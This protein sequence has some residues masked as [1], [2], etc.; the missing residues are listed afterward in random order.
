MH[1]RLREPRY[2]PVTAL[3]TSRRRPRRS[4]RVRTGEGIELRWEN[5]LAG[6]RSRPTGCGPGL[7]SCS[8]RH[9]A[10]WTVRR[11]R[12]IYLTG[13]GDSHYAGL[14]DAARLRALER[15]PDPGGRVA[16]TV[17]LRARARARRLLGVC[18][19]NSGK[20]VRTVEA[21]AEARQRG[22]RAIGVT[23][24]A[25]SP[26]AARRR[27][28][29]R[30]PLRRPGVRAGDDL[31]RRLPRRAVCAG[32]PRGRAGRR[33]AVEPDCQAGRGRP[34]DVRGVQCGLPS[35]SA[36]ETAGR[37]EGRL[38]RRRP[39]PRDGVVR[40]RED[41]RGR[42]R[43]GRS[44]RARG[45]GAR[46]VLLHRPRGDDDRRRAC[47][48]LRTTARSSSSP[49]HGRSAR[50]PSRSARPD[51]ARLP[52]QTS[53]F[54]SPATR[55]RLLSPLAYCVPLE[56]LAYHYASTRGLTMLGFDDEKRKALNFRQIFGEY[57]AR[58]L[59]VGN[60]LVENI[61]MPDGREL[62]DRLGGD[63]IYAASRRTGLR[64]RR[65]ARR[66]PWPGLSA[67]ACRRAR[68]GRV[69]GRPDPVRA[70]RRFGFASTGA[71]RTAAGSPSSPAPAHTS[72][73][74]RC[75]RSFPITSPTGSR[76]CTSRRSRSSRWRRGSTGRARARE[77]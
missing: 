29:A 11:R 49:P 31:L 14:A 10:C 71:S 65:P 59:T 16:R 7:P 27:G 77:C 23:F 1:P 54:P 55:P 22:L 69:R 26:L 52:R 40:A 24:D 19:S 67:R 50:R 12:A 68:A 44:A 74:R 21:A 43:A 72:R 37:R 28:D 47:P 51:R 8:R 2:E 75:P 36:R 64:R 30:L 53:C 76:R 48:A 17:A 18:V 32:S 25:D 34:P 5:M 45:V 38:R 4:A 70:S 39:K 63:A 62:R 60:L 13:C 33:D 46:G 35:A 73:R 57:V 6:I 15:D 9:A 20:V 56:L 66:P 41:D 42:P 61:V 58:Y 3:D